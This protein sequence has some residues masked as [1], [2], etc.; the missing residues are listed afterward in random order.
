MYSIVIDLEL[1]GPATRLLATKDEENELTVGSRAKK[2][3]TTLM[4]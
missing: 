1:E 4:V 2:R 3:K